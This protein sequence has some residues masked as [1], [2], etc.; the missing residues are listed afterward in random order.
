MVVTV[1][2]AS[3]REL[4]VDM[5]LPQLLQVE[6]RVNNAAEQELGTPIYGVKIHERTFKGKCFDCGKPGHTRARCI[7][8]KQDQ[9]VLDK[10]GFRRAVAF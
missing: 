5:V 7:K 10:G 8:Q 1:L 6:Q 4:T 9:A 3:D 2:E